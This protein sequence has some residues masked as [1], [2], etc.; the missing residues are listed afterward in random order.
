MSGPGEV[1]HILTPR[2][3]AILA[4]E[5]KR[6]QQ[7]EQAVAASRDVLSRMV[8]LLVDREDAVLDWASGEVRVA[9]PSAPQ[10]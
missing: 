4:P 8:R 9:A 2:Q 1:Q 5:V 7:A 10:V 3:R 6:L